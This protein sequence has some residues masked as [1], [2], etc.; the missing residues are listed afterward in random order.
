MIVAI[1]T[2]SWHSIHLCCKQTVKQA[3]DLYVD[4]ALLTGE[5]YPAEKTIAPPMTDAASAT[6]VARNLV[7]MGSSVVSGTAKARTKASL[8][9]SR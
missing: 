4:E 2:L 6:A 3:R 1:L 5:S 9:S 8:L 7:Y